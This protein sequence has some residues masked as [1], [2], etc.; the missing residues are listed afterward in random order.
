L[1]QHAPH[2]P[3]EKEGE[4]H[5]PETADD[6]DNFYRYRVAGAA[7]ELFIVQIVA[8]A[9]TH[10]FPNNPDVQLFLSRQ[11][12]DDGAHSLHT[13]QR[14]LELSGRDP[15]EDIQQQVQRHWNYL[16]DIPTRNWIAFLSWELHYE[17]YIVA[18]SLLASRL[19][20]VSE[21]KSAQFAS[22]R[23]LPDEAVH[24]QD[25][26]AW[27]KREYEQASL[28]QRATLIAELIEVDNDIQ[29]RRNP[30]LRDFWQRA[31]RALSFEVT[32]FETIYDAFRKEVLAVLL[33]IPAEQL[34]P[35][36]S[37]KD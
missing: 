9:I 8:K 37:I 26:V 10:L 29:R 34:P 13:R 7:H 15:V 5:P 3:L 19:T 16:G 20:K 35:L 28:G 23:I 2:I 31:Q 36:V 21:P 30:Y 14:V 1:I 33:E 32:E 12:G 6:W 22:D 17:L 18:I 24:R 11:L 25:V 27:W 4:P